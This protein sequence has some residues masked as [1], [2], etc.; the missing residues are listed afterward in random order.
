MNGHTFKSIKV[1]D[2]EYAVKLDE[3]KNLLVPYVTY[4]PYAHT[5]EI[6]Y[7]QIDR[8]LIKEMVEE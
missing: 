2:E 7:L 3:D 1:N 5:M 8:E 4:S 6:N